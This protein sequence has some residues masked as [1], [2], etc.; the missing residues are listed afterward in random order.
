MPGLPL[1]RP[2]YFVAGLIALLGLLLA[3]R[4]AVQA[5]ATQQVRLV[6]EEYRF[7]PNTVSLT[8]GQP[9][10]I[11]L[12]DSGK[13]AHDLKSDIPVSNLAYQR[14]ANDADEQRANSQNGTMDVDVN[15]GSTSQITFVPT[16]PGTYQF[17]C[18]VPGHK[19]AGMVGTF[20]VAEAQDQATTAPTTLP[21]A[22]VPG[23][24]LPWLAGGALLLVAGGLAV[25]F[26]PRAR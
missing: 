19:G 9:V 8:V 26:I 2:A 6:T 1:P 15:S 12:A 4:V 22:G 17:F 14:A 16:R 3:G 24:A 18:D 11:T 5:S 13:L 10:E 25:R 20:V 7:T 21:S 23:G